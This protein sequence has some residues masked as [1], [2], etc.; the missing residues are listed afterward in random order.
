ML[1]WDDPLFGLYRRSL[2]VRDEVRDMDL[3]AYYCELADALV[4]QASDDSGQ[5]ADLAYAAQLARTLSLKCALYDRLTRAYGE[6]DR[7]VLA[8]LAQ[9]AI[10]ELVAQVKRLWA[11][12]RRVWMAQ[13]KAFGFEVQCVRYGG[14]IQRLEEVALRINEYLS[15]QVAGIEELDV[16]GGSLP[17]YLNRYRS[18]V[19]SS[20]IL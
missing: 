1:L 7:P 6:G 17:E 8:D 9:R 13:N 16:P 3:P 10:P 18:V 4:T 11:E 15:G 19:S 12:H 5:A 2:L 20:S 14:L